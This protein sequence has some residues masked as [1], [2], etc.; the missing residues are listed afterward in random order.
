[1]KSFLIKILFLFL[2]LLPNLVI[3]QV[4]IPYSSRYRNYDK[5]SCVY[6]STI[7]VFNFYSTSNASRFAIYIRNNSSGGDYHYYLNKRLRSWKIKTLFTENA[8][9]SV[10]NYAHT[11][12][13]PA[14]ISYHRNHS[15][16]FLGWYVDPVTHRVSHAYILNPNHT[17]R[18]ETPT[19]TQF[20][21][22]WFRNDGEAVVILP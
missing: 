15:C 9:L 17:H 4:Y 10:L 11:H 22:N 13:I 12:K 5:G 20:Y 1:M 14:I 6:A 19:Y 2:I 8:N 3:A 21:L 16:L 18:I 7:T